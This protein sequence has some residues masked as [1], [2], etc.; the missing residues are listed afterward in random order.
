LLFN[1]G[2]VPF[3]TPVRADPL[4]R[5]QGRQFFVVVTLAAAFL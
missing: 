1:L 3:L 5:R 4:V 2:L